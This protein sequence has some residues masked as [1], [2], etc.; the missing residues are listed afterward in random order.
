[1]EHGKRQHLLRRCIETSRAEK[2]SSQCAEVY[3]H[4]TGGSMCQ[5]KRASRRAATATPG[6]AA[7]A[8]AAAAAGAARELQQQQEQQILQQRQ[9]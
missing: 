4:P 9:Q 8:A 5:F 7:A 1:M 3:V 2:A 6:A